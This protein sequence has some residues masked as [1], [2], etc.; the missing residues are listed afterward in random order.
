MGASAS[1]K[2]DLENKS[3]CKAAISDAMWQD[4]EEKVRDTFRKWDAD[5]NGIISLEELDRIF[6]KLRGDEKKLSTKQL[7]KI[8]SLVDSNS[9]GEVS[10]EELIAW[11][12]CAPNLDKYFEVQEQLLR[13]ALA[14]AKALLQEAQSKDL[15]EP[16]KASVVLTGLGEKLSKL[17]ADLL[18][19]LEGAL[20]PL[21]K[22]AFL[23]H[24][25]DGSGKL[26]RE[27]SIIFFSNFAERSLRFH[28]SV[29]GVL[30]SIQMAFVPMPDPTALH[31]RIVEKLDEARAR[32]KE[33][34]GFYFRRAFKLLDVSNDSKLELEEVMRAL[35][36]HTQQ[37]AD[38]MQALGLDIKAAQ[39]V[40]NDPKD[41][42]SQAV[43]E[44]IQEGVCAMQ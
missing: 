37:H 24:D 28:A 7:A 12:F 3:L 8:F 35:L 25:K 32:L 42:S 27:E 43:V 19:K 40:G 5:G 15:S 11:L 36:P 6:S 10:Y 14:Q 18:K 17:Q 26:E 39:L 13:E 31:A 38:L 1:K 21:I 4:P 44:S 16:E 2:I 30:V 41:A 20:T 22:K 34:C 23:W 33:D 9:D 29:A